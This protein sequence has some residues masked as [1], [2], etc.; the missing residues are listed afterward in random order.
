M[1][2]ERVARDKLKSQFYL[3]FWR[4]NFMSC[5]RVAPDDL[6]IAILFQFLAIEPH[7]VRKGC[8]SC[9]LVGTAPRLQERNRK[10]GEG[11]RARGEDAKMWGCEEWE[12]KRARGEDVKMWGCEERADVKMRRCENERMRRCEDEQL[13]RCEDVKM[14]GCEDVRM[15]RWEDVRWED[16]KMRRCEDVRMWRWAAVKMW[17]CEDERM[18]RCEDVKMRGCEDERVW[19]C[20][21]EKMWRCEDVK[22]G[23][24]EEEKMF[25]RP[26]LLEEPCAQTLSGKKKKEEG[27]KWRMKTI[28]CSICNSSMR[29]SCYWRHLKTEKHKEI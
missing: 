11:K 10:E 13:W 19:R 28:T 23:R 14:R 2:C 17:G 6:E 1:S 26:P 21:D 3:T 7:F 20:E 16:V 4:S 27:F 29:Q 22:M 18:W 9:R 12:G 8:V 24:C 5:E 15:W 25:Y